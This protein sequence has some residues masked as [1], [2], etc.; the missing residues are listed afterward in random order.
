[1]VATEQI[2]KQRPQPERLSIPVH[3]PA[4]GQ[5]IGSVAQS[6]EEA[7]AAAVARAR[8]AQPVWGTMS[9]KER[10]RILR[11]WGD[12]LWE[13]QQQAMQ[14]I[15]DETGKNDTGAFLEIMGIDN[16]VAYYTT[17]APRLLKTE[18]ARHYFQSFKVLVSTRSR[19]VLPASLPHGTI[20]WHW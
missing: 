9:T 11:R 4:T 13:R 12:M 17:R 20:R 7:V 10:C 14:V 5:M 1:M 3:N 16:A 2:N 8:E 18:N 19:M 6:T 15:R